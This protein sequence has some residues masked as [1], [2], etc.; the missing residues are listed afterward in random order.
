MQ[1]V[2]LLKTIDVFRGLS[3]AQHHAIAA[4]TTTE[5][6]AT[7]D[8][9]FQQ[10]AM[11]D[12]LYIVCAGQVEI[13]VRDTQGQDKALVYLG[14]GQ[15]V[16]E[17]T[18]VDEGTRSATAIASDNPTVVYS[19]ANQALID[20]CEQNTDIGYYLMRNIAQDLS[21]KLRHR[22]HQPSHPSSEA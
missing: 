19:I 16:G 20:L 2:D 8:V 14:E 21:F 1:V 10:G 5:T 12:K 7:G 6:F 17:M 9:I 4:I 11:A 13:T 22:G 3:D 15:V 18:L